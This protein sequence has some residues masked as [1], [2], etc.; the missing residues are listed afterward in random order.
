MKSP[1]IF[2]QA[3]WNSSR[4]PHM[5]V[6]AAVRT[7]SWEAAF[8]VAEPAWRGDPTSPWPS[9]CPRPPSW[10][11]AATAGANASTARTAR[12]LSI[13]RSSELRRLRRTRPHRHSAALSEVGE[14]LVAPGRGVRLLLAELREHRAV[15]PGI[16]LSL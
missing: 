2:R 13:D 15:T 4:G 12:A 3:K 10:A 9:I 8:Q 14:A 7:Y 6:P 16:D 5:F 11:S 1:F